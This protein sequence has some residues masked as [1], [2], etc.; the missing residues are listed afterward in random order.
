MTYFVTLLVFVISLLI[1]AGLAIYSWRRRQFPGAYSF[2]IST[3]LFTIWPLI[4][5]IDLS[6]TDLDLKILLMK[7]RID[8]PVFGGIAWL[9]MVAQLTGREKLV[10]KT[11]LAII[12]SIP[13]IT[14]LLNLTGYST[15]FRHGYYV[16]QSGVFP[17]L[18]WTNGFWFWIWF[19]WSNAIFV[20]PFFLLA[21]SFRNLTVLTRQQ[22]LGILFALILPLVVNLLFQMGITP[23]KG[24]N[25]TPAVIAYSGLVIVWS[26]YRYHLFE[27]VPIARG[28]LIDSITDGV[29]VLD[30]QNRIVDANP[31]IL[32]MIEKNR[33]DVIAKNARTV[34]AAWPDLLGRFDNLP[35]THTE[36]FLDGE[37]AHYFNLSISPLFDTFNY[38]S[39]RLITIRD[40]TEHKQIEKEL[41]TSRKNIRRLLESAPDAMLMVNRDGK[42]LFVNK[43][44]ELMFGYSREELLIH[45]IELLL[46]E[47]LSNIHQKLG[48]VFYIEPKTRPRGKNPDLEITG[49]RKDGSE[50][51]CEISLNTLEYDTKPIVIASVRDVT[52]RKQAEAAR[53]RAELDLQDAL[54]RTNILYEITNAAISSSSLD[55]LLEQTAQNV[56]SGM[57]AD[58]V[59]LITLDVEKKKI[60]NFARGGTHADQVALS[61]SYTELINGLSGWAIVNRKSALSLK[62]EP[63][64]RE[65][66]SVQRRRKETNCGSILV[67]PLLYQ[68][69]I[70][71]TI[72]VINQPDEPDFTE[73]DAG[74]LEAIAA[75]VASAIVKI[76][77]E[78]NIKGYNKRLSYLHETTLDLLNHRA[79]DGLLQSIIDQASGFLNAPYCEI[80]LKEGDELVVKAYTRNQDFLEG[81]RVRRGEAHLSWQA[82]DTRLPAV[83]N[84]YSKWPLRRDL[85]SDLHLSAVASIPI[86]AHG[87]SIGVLDLSRTQPWKPFDESEIHAATLFTQLA[88]IA[89]DNAQLHENL[90]EEAIRDPLTGLFNRRFMEETLIKELGRA[91]RR[92]LLLTLVMLDMDNLKEVNDTYGHDVGDDAIAHISLLLRAKIRTGDTACRYGGDEFIVILPETGIDIAKRRMDEFLE[93]VRNQKI[94]HNGKPIKPVTLS[95][96]IAEYPRNGEMGSELFKAADSALY[97]AKE[98]GRNIVVEA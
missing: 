5:A 83:V 85:Y 9:V 17:T 91:Q 51:P 56:A 11:R 10:T 87:M 4:Q 45:S 44:C 43:Q 30:T 94:Y 62:G 98:A 2:F 82:F 52:E 39:G 3:I 14:L 78:E 74:L 8:A 70:L 73:N 21:A 81:D 24:F 33:E 35:A 77:L 6:V 96:G 67:T 60:R 65:S 53:I 84:E 25:F 64:P 19:V 71:G 95:V 26:V 38:P 41:D 79:I 50:F 32:R 22:I 13:L 28:L 29:L 49:R 93:D 12:S 31:A 34:F 66:P 69:D 16:D 47:S 92:S 90:R 88:A 7:G 59:A 20:A 48:D 40:I 61:V 63:D 1:N 27:V 15:I 76:S 42:L 37:P 86:I 55:T 75:Q 58:R 54:K 80:L 97:K 89:L 46:P 36:I 57:P 68:E 18:H 72:T 23:L